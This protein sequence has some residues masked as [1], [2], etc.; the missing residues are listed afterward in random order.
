MS[1]FPD[2]QH[3]PDGRVAESNHCDLV[4]GGSL[5]HRASLAGR[6]RVPNGY[7]RRGAPGTW[8]ESRHAGDVAATYLASPREGF[9]LT[10]GGLFRA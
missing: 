1:S 8:G 6:G 7:P 4:V 10:R 2:P 9:S 5:E 3:T